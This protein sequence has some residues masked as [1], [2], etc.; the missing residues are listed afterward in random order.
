MFLL[1]TG[2]AYGGWRKETM[3]KTIK[4]YV[5]DV[6][7][8]LQEE[9]KDQW[10]TLTMEDMTRRFEIPAY[11]ARMTVNTIRLH[12]NVRYRYL[13]SKSRFKPKEYMYA[14][15]KKEKLADALSD[16][17]Q[18]ELTED[19]EKYLKNCLGTEYI[20]NCLEQYYLIGSLCEKLKIKALSE[21]WS[22]ISGGDYAR[23]FDRST[24][25]ITYC[26]GQMEKSR[27]L[28]KN[29][30]TD[31]Y[32][33]ILS[34]SVYVETQNAVAKHVVANP[35]EVTVERPRINFDETSDYKQIPEVNDFVENIQQ[36]LSLNERMKKILLDNARL[37]EQLKIKDDALVKQSYT[38]FALQDAY[39]QIKKQYE[40]VEPV[41]KKYQEDYR[42]ISEYEKARTEK[43]E[44]VLTALKSEIMSDVEEYA[45]LPVAEKNKVATT[46]R[47]KTRLLDAVYNA[48][49]DI[50]DFKFVTKRE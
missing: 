11:Y 33:L 42:I 31:S 21:D 10:A 28:I 3:D 32:R 14:E 30:Y 36:M 46:S 35:A 4:E 24:L 44:E 47:F 50:Q 49:K 34:E 8:Y 18:F 41:I 7:S 16:V 40:N 9:K 37:C 12:P 1:A 2:L 48:S 19:E 13:P 43:I 23:L 27:L 20:K 25:D 38:F 29:P 6:L 26:V 5:A 22:E 17:A 45:K 39:E 15:D